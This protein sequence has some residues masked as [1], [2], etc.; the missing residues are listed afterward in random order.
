MGMGTGGR[1]EEWNG[2]GGG[3]EGC[4]WAGLTQLLEAGERLTAPQICT[5]EGLCALSLPQA[6]VHLRLQA[7]GTPCW[8]QARWRHSGRPRQAMGRLIVMPGAGP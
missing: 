1:G 5:D 7:K 2:A 6:L 4:R 3:M 8:G